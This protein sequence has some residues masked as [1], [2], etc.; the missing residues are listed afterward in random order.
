MTLVVL[1]GLHIA[2]LA[3]AVLAAVPWLAGSPRVARLAVWSAAAGCLSGIAGLTLRTV[4]SGHLPIFGTLE[5]TWTCGTV[6]LVTA[7]V[8]TIRRGPAARYAPL[9]APWAVLLLAWGLRTRFAPVPLTI[10]EQSIWVDLHVGLAW[11][12]FVPLLWA[13]TIS[14]SR[15]VR[16]RTVEDDDV[17]G[18]LVL[19][20][21]MLGYVFLSA[22]IVAGAWYLFVLFG[23]FWRWE[24]VGVSALVT[25]LGYSIAAHG[26]L[27]QG[28]RGSRF[29]LVVAIT[30]VPL[31]ILFWIWSV[32][33]GTYHF[34][35][36]PLLPPY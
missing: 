28:W 1:R 11:A 25:W 24:V 8:S 16:P 32:F 27:I 19:R 18:A 30:L 20:L 9:L 31:L 4:V 29:F 17:V 14:A 33:P 35:D 22:M 21:M 2:T 15:L 12:A 13:G 3:F 26:W 34:F 7:V 23:T 36:I 6:L 10:S 5:N